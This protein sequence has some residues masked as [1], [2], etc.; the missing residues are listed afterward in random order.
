[1]QENVPEDITRESDWRC[2]QVAGPLDFSMVGVIASLTGILAAAN[3][4][5]F[6]ISTFDTDLLLVKQGDLEAAV[7]VF[8]AAGHDCTAVNPRSSRGNRAR[9]ST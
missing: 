8:A 7:D 3:I 9:R 1:L 6:V 2:L 5:V 4:S